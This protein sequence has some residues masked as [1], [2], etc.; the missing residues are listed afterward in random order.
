[1]TQALVPPV[2]TRR[3]RAPGQACPTTACDPYGEPGT[4]PLGWTSSC[5]K[6]DASRSPD[7]S[8]F[9]DSQN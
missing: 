6:G 9:T 3:D 4:T 7:S 2:P 8:P 1:M 5:R